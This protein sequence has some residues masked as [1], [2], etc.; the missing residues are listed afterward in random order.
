M[1]IPGVVLAGVPGAGGYDAVFA[2]T[3]GELARDKVVEQ[4]NRKGV[5]TLPTNEDPCGV[6]LHEADP[7]VNQVGSSLEAMSLV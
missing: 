6:S 2:I 1:K 4:W 3:L 5:L 7:R